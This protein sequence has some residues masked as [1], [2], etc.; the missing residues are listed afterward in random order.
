MGAGG[1]RVAGAGSGRWGEG[2]QHHAALVQGALVGDWS[3]TSEVLEGQVGLEYLQVEEGQLQAVRG[4]G[5]GEGPGLGRDWSPAC[6]PKQGA[7][8]AFSPLCPE[9]QKGFSGAQGSWKVLVLL[10]LAR[11]RVPGEG[12]ILTQRGTEKKE[13]VMAALALL[14]PRRK[15]LDGECC[16]WLARKQN[17][18]N[19]MPAQRTGVSPGVGWGEEGRER[20]TQQGRLGSPSGLSLP[21]SHK[22]LPGV[23]LHCPQGV[24]GEGGTGSF[25]RLN[26]FNVSIN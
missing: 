7:R 3:I 23:E 8:I 16:H 2:G 11:Q 1:G 13:K 25:L 21:A 24:G 12:L 4:W 22:T 5:G 15:C 19:Q 6:C 14:L 9:S 10:P 17:P 18:T 20:K 26:Q